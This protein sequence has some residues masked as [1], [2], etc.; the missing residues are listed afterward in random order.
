MTP[1]KS[2][3][4]AP[5]TAQAIME[6]PLGLAFLFFSPNGLQRLAFAGEKDF[7]EGMVMGSTPEIQALP[8]GVLK[9]W[10]DRVAQALEDYFAGNPASFDSLDLDQQG[11]PFQLR[12]WQELRKIP[13]GETVSYQ[14]LAR[15]L[16]NPKAARAVGQAL[17]ANPLPLIIPCH[18]V[19]AGNGSLGG[20]SS[21]LDRK[22]RLLR[23]E[24]VDF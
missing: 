17:G 2:P 8:Q 3:L 10:H 12:V 4:K 15:R 24:G 9:D 14:E 20:Y 22:R 13:Y 18:R 1:R 5:L 19:I 6:T 23:H 7:K 16:G 21:G 11:T